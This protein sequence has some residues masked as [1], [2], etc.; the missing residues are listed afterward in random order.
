MTIGSNPHVPQ[1]NPLGDISGTTNTNLGKVTTGGQNANVEQNEKAQGTKGVARSEIGQIGES[2]S[3]KEADAVTKNLPPQDPESPEIPAPREFKPQNQVNQWLTSF[4]LTALTVNFTAIAM[5][6]KDIHKAE[7]AFA[8]KMFEKVWKMAVQTADLIMAKA[9]TEAN[10]HLALAISAMVGLAV[11]VAGTALSIAGSFKTAGAKIRKDAL[12]APGDG[13]D[14]PKPTE[15]RA[16]GTPNAVATNKTAPKPLP[17]R[18]VADVDVPNQPTVTQPSA[19]KDASVQ[20]ATGQK[21]PPNPTAEKE[22]IVKDRRDAQV[23][24]AV[25]QG[26]QAGANSVREIIDN[27]VQMIFKPILAKFD[28]DIEKTRAIKELASKALDSSIQ[29]FNGGTD[30]V[31]GATRAMDKLSE[32][33]KANSINSR[34]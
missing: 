9:Q 1:S 7:G 28:G 30:I 33:I 31:D 19:R 26:M 4:F 10:M 29:A 25:G 13:P 16:G 23:F 34:G 14:A 21:E 20:K 32:V 6:G 15:A 12:K 3:L 2:S 24:S 17:K 22:R 18:P 27:I 5:L 11:S 8:V